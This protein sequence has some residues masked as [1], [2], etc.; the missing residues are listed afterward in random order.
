MQI[1]IDASNSTNYANYDRFS[2]AILF[3]NKWLHCLF[4]FLFPENDKEMK[5]IIKK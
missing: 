5:I 2:E 1:A 4:H 3:R